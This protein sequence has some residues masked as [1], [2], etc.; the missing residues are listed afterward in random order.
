LEKIIEAVLDS[1]PKMGLV[2][3]EVSA[4]HV[5]LSQHDL[6]ILF[7]DKAM[8]T[9]KRDLSQIGQFLSEER[10]N[11]I[12]PKGRKER[13]AVLGPVR[14]DTQVELSKNDCVDLGVKAPLRESGDVEGSGSI[15]IEGPCASIEIK[16]GVIIAHKHVHVPTDLAKTLGFKDK[17]RVSVQIFS[18]RPVIFKDVIIRISDMAR[19]RMHIDFDEANAAAV[20]GFTLGQ[21][22]W[23][24]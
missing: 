9:P 3:V 12:G 14:G 8:L 24:K 4:R 5:H 10:V 13:I 23:K 19:F 16:Q 2:E 21:I 18:G 22:L 11:L 15:V 6:E 1:I 17:Q 7:G 20:S